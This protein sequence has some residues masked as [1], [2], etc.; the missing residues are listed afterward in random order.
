MKD[1]PHLLF[2][3]IEFYLTLD[4]ETIT[5]NAPDEQYYA[6]KNNPRT[7]STA[8]ERCVACR[9]ISLKTYPNFPVKKA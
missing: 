7:V 5:A 2:N 3:I 6:F 4:G 8:K 1:C 9:A